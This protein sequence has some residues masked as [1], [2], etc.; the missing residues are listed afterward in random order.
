MQQP[1]LDCLSAD[2][3][4]SYED[5]ISALFI[6]FGDSLS[7][8]QA[9]LTS[10]FLV[11]EGGVR[12]CGRDTSGDE[13]TI[14]RLGAGQWWGGWSGLSS[15]ASSSCRTTADTKL[16][17]VPVEVWQNFWRSDSRLGSWLEKN[18]QRED[19]YAALRSLLIQRELQDLSLSY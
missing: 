7:Q 1:P 17:S 6:P 5:Q 16:L 4:Q 18:P 8:E 10:V 3:I 14:R 11:V 2:L 15:L 19:L 9:P 12:V 13:F